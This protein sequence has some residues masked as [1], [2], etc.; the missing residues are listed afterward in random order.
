MED[1]LDFLIEVLNNNTIKSNNSNIIDPEISS[2]IISNNKIS[3]KEITNNITHN[4]ESKPLTENQKLS[5][6][7]KKLK[8]KIN[9]NKDNKDK[10]NKENKEI[11]IYEPSN[12]SYI[13]N[14]KK[15]LRSSKSLQHKEED[16][17]LFN[18]KNENEFKD[19]IL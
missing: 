9:N 13:K 17:I 2:K 15:K 14:H 1:E 10:E 4:K 8:E 5:V 16:K 18:F 11:K 12:L 7:I 6:E 3:N 19:K